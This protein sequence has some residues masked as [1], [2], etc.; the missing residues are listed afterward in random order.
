MFR[1]VRKR[2]AY[3]FVRSRQKK[4]EEGA[5]GTIPTVERGRIRRYVSCDRNMNQDLTIATAKCERDLV[6]QA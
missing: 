5:A 1:N 3:I 4:F 6:V 2:H